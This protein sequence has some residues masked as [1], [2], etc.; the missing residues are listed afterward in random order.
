MDGDALMTLM[1]DAC[2]RGDTQVFPALAR[3]YAQICD[4]DSIEIGKLLKRA[5]H[6]Y[7]WDM[8]VCIMNNAHSNESGY[9]LE[10]F[11]VDLFLRE[12]LEK[13]LLLHPYA[14]P[15]WDDSGFESACETGNVTVVEYFADKVSPRA[16]TGGF[17][18][19][20]KYQPF[21]ADRLINT[22]NLDLV[23]QLQ[24]VEEIDICHVIRFATFPID[25]CEAVLRF[26]NHII[27]TRDYY[28]Q[29]Y[30]THLSDLITY[31]CKSIH[32]SI[33]TH[34]L[35]NMLTHYDKKRDDNVHAAVM[36]YLIYRKLV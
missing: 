15:Q 26:H 5:L 17:A 21:I 31:L 20:C 6:S 19:A 11:Y 16:I 1:K 35:N 28:G 27:N 32:D 33:P 8:I 3:Q 13:I 36:T 34:V 9:E 10:E 2:S 14:K 23:S 7:D 12:P 22:L 4:I 25:V 24:L 29:G 30:S 18:A